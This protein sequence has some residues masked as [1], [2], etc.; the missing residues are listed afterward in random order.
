MTLPN[1]LTPGQNASRRLY[2]GASLSDNE[3][4]QLGIGPDDGKRYRFEGDGPDQE[5]FCLGCFE[6]MRGHHHPDCLGGKR[7]GTYRDSWE[8]LMKPEGWLGCS[9]EPNHEDNHSDS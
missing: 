4:H 8:Y 7:C 5:M 9:F 3:R 1:G 6:N 2:E